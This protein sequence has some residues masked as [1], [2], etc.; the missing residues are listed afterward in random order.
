[1]MIKRSIEAPPGPHDLFLYAE[2][3]IRGGVVRANFSPQVSTQI[4]H[5]INGRSIL[6]GIKELFAAG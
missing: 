4:H 1:M 3:L 6:T 2:S 5:I